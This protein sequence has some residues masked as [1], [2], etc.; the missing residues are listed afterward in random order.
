MQ[1]C[2]FN[3]TDEDRHID[4][5]QTASPMAWCRPGPLWRYEP[6]ETSLGDPAARQ[7]FETMPVR[8]A[9]DDGRGEVGRLPGPGDQP[10]RAATAGEAGFDERHGRR[11]SR[12]C[13]RSARCSATASSAPRR[14]TPTTRPS[15]WS[16]PRRPPRGRG[17]CRRRGGPAVIGSDGGQPPKPLPSF[18]RALLSAARRRLASSCRIGN[19][20][21]AVQRSVADPLSWRRDVA[22]P[23][24]CCRGCSG[25]VAPVP[26]QV[27]R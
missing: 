1:G 14:A 12:R 9:L 10:A 5:D 21:V 17:T 19:N 18:L 11:D 15:G 13:K 3:A 4:Q 23:A 24:A 6:A 27:F 7:G 8:W 16:R 22:E 26:W 2:T 25:W 20:P